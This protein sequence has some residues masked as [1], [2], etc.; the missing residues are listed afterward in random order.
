MSTQVAFPKPDFGRLY[1][2]THD[3]VTKAQVIRPNRVLKV[4][5]GIPKGRAVHIFMHNKEW[6]IRFGVWEDDNGKKKLKMKTV[7]R[8]NSIVKVNGVDTKLSN[9]RKDVES[10]YHAHK[11]DAA[12]SNRPQKIQ[13]FTFTARTVREDEGGKPVEIF[14]PDFE[15]IEAH[16]DAPRR[17][18]IVLTTS[19][20]L[21]QED[22]W[23]T[24]AELKCHGD[25]LLGERVLS[26]GSPKDEWWERAKAAGLKMFPIQP[27]RLAG[28]PHAGVDCKNHSN[29]EFQLAGALRLGSTAYF[30]STGQVTAERLASSL[31]SIKIPVE[32]MG[33]SVV[34]A[35]MYLV[36]GSF[37]A[38][39]DGKPSIQ[40]AA[41]LEFT[42]SSMAAMRKVLQ[43]TSWTPRAIEQVTRMIE[44]APGAPDDIVNSEL[45]APAVMAEFSDA[46][47]EDEEPAAE[48]GP[49]A[50]ATQAKTDALSEKIAK[51]K[52]G[53]GAAAP[54]PGPVVNVPVATPSA[55]PQP[56]ATQPTTPWP[57]RAGM[58]AAMNAQKSRIGL[59]AWESLMTK[60]SVMMGS[61]KHDDPKAL[62]L[63]TDAVAAP[64]IVLDTDVF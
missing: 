62:A 23:W 46:E 59:A 29:I 63:Y 11:N 51:A 26:A 48:A 18:P 58:N 45:S 14:E 9:E 10:W 7:Y 2:I 28:C 31:A 19:N 27:C 12:V 50:A 20:P 8:G 39:K 4:G 1:G 35:T 57:D 24:A 60:H 22:Q 32:N 37:K 17:I 33:L 43:E 16:G 36:L 61:L 13:H 3:A 52:E 53:K 6:M 47:F 44:A 21:R 5:I 25:G 30:A 64:A 41:W 34:G 49:A 55:V 15:A 54:E 42:E 38:N 56:A 40:P